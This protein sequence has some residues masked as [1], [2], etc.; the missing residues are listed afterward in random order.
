MFLGRKLS[1]VRRSGDR[2]GRRKVRRGQSREFPEFAPGAVRA[3]ASRVLTPSEANFAISRIR[4]PYQIDL[5]TTTTVSGNLD[6][7]ANCGG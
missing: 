3:S 4:Q 1:G 6:R 5:P 2:H 7:W